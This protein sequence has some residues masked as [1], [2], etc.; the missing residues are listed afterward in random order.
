MVREDKSTWESLGRVPRIF[1]GWPRSKGNIRV[2]RVTRDVRS[3]L[4]VTWALH[5]PGY[6]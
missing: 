2:T 1:E 4:P 3:D 6:P 5:D